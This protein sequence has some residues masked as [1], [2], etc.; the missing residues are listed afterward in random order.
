[1]NVN[2][3]L[4]AILILF[5]IT[6][7]KSIAQDV[8]QKPLNDFLIILEQKFNV[9]F[10][11]ADENIQ[12]IFVTI[13]LNK[14]GI[15]EYLAELEKQTKLEFKKLDSRYITIQRKIVDVI[16]SGTIIDKSTK[17]PL[18]GANIYTEKYHSLSDD[19]GRFSIKIIPD[20]DS[21][22]NISYLGYVPL[23][24]DP[25]AWSN[26][27]LLCELN[28]DIINLE[29][30]VFNYIAKGISKLADGSIQFNA[31]NLEI[32]P[33]LSEPDML[34]SV[35]ILPGIQ[36]VNKTVSDINIRGGTND[37]NLILWDGVKMY[38]TGHF[39]GLISAFNS[40]LVHKTQIVKNGASAYY[41]EG[42]SGIIDMKQQDYLS[43]EFEVSS[44]VN[45]ISADVILK[46]PINQKFSMI[47]GAR[48]S[49]NNLVITPT[50]ES[51]YKRAFEYTDVLQYQS[52]DTIVDDYHNF[53]FYDLSLKLL[54]DITDKDKIRL[55]FLNIDNQI[56]YEESAL[57]NDTLY[58]NKSSL[59]QSSILSSFNYS[60]SWNE[61]HSA[62]ISAFVSNYNLDGINVSILND[63]Q[64]LQKNEVL[65]WGVKLESKNK[66]SQLINLS[67]GYQFNEVGIR[68]Q[69]NISKPNYNRDIKDV[70]RIH[71]LYSETELNKL[72]D[73]VY[74]RFGLR[75]NYFQKFSEFI[76]EPRVALNYKLTK[77]ISFEVL[78]ESKSQHTTQLIDYQTDFLGIEKRR[79]V[80]SN[81]NSVPI[82]KSQQI[83]LGTHYNRNN[84]LLSIEAYKKKN[85]GIVTPSQ[86]F[87]NQ[88]QYVYAI[89]KYETQGIELLID[90]RFRKSNIWINYALS[91]N[92]YYFQEFTPSNFPNNVDIRHTLS[93]GGSYNIK[94]IELSSGFNYRTGK[95]YTKLSQDNTDNE[96]EIIYEDPNSCRLDDYIR[97]DI[98]AKYNFK[99][100]KI[101]GELGV[102]V[103]N[104][105]N[106]ENHI[107]KFYQ[108]NDNNEIEEIT[109]HALKITP[110][111]NL[112]L[113]F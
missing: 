1:M 99:I 22:L 75:A 74:L 68:N 91:T 38:Q 35:Q 53:S 33:G 103:W 49:I 10:T 8:E 62:D 104:I 97:L 108:L 88:Y 92:D 28:R 47:L 36:S 40:Y 37:Q 90:K 82:I 27:S 58:T 3:F 106:R 25:R 30:V 61:N 56:E 60:H 29:E 113:T 24:L 14:L 41:A 86:G 7:N 96:N 12:D 111:I 15:D 101:K 11:Y 112:R 13:Q 65:D 69:D 102:S 107:N 51:Y 87:Q 84:F 46:I 26:D 66:L 45:M 48:H 83:S 105:L 5:I 18:V 80:L 43:K 85:D 32:L 55:S 95:P 78:A 50:Y 42:V 52:N 110:N 39:F 20:E 57:I 16:I 4:I 31:R 19:K 9:V 6:S 59:N 77:N 44:G 34:H 67:T 94:N 54:Y 70:L 100:K 64:H 98:S 72:F 71:S 79:W 89:G 2:R 93:L 81:N 109:Q 17:E 23:K 21:L 63:Q 76:F 73:K